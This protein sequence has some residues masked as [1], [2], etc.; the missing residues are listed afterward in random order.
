[1]LA[2][3]RAAPF[4]DIGAVTD[5]GPLLVLA[6]HPDDESLGCGGTIAAATAHGIAVHLAVLTDGTGSHRGSRCY[7]PAR[8]K[9][10]R[11]A[12]TRA[13]AAAL[14]LAPAQ[15]TFLEAIDSQAPTE[16]AAF[17]A[18]VRRLAGLIDRLHAR[19]VLTTWRHDPHCDHEAAALLGAA[20]AQATG[21]RLLTTPVWGWTLPDAMLLPGPIPAA[22]RLDIAAHLPAKRRAIAAHV[23]QTTGLIDDAP[24][25]FRLDPRFLAL[26]ARPWEVMIAS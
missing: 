23:S 20:A 12:E 13:A 11:A 15:V 18:L 4:A 10:L 5:G 24:D 21:A 26:F 16:G 3:F 9:A 22:V 25:G 1:M 8:L 6:P 17:D 19:C 2:A 14:G 7:P